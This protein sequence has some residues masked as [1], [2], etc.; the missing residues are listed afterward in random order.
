MNRCKSVQVDA[1]WFKASKELI[2]IGTTNNSTRAAL[3]TRK[4][5][6]TP[7]RLGFCH[8]IFRSNHG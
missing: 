5:G 1:L 8:V 2:F 7:R 3:R 6:A 4:I